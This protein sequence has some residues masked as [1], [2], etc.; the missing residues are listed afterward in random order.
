VENGAQYANV[1]ED[2]LLHEASHTVSKDAGALNGGMLPGGVFGD[3]PEHVVQSCIFREPGWNV[4]GI[5]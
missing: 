1:T 5:K 3:G 4:V 2:V